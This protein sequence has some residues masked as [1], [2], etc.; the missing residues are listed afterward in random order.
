MN[1]NFGD[2]LLYKELHDTI[3]RKFGESVEIISSEVSEFY[4]QFSPVIR[5]PHF[6]AMKEADFIVFGGGGYFGEGTRKKFLWNL[7]FVR[8]YGLKATSIAMAGKKFII[9]GVG[10]GPFK[11]FFSRWMTRYIFNRADYIS[12]RDNESKEFLKRIGVKKD[13]EMH[14]DWILGM[15]VKDVIATAKLSEKVKEVCQ[16]EYL[17][18]HL[19]SKYTDN[20]AGLGL[21]TKEILAYCK[22]KDVKV[23]V[24]CDQTKEDVYLRTKELSR[25]FGDS[26][27][28]YYEYKSPYELISLIGS[29]KMIITDKL[30][31]G[32]VGV[33]AGTNVVS[34]PL[35][36]KTPRL[37]KQIG[38]SDYCKPIKDVAQGD[39]YKLLDKAYNNIPSDMSTIC[40]AS[41]Y[42][43]EI[44]ISKIDALISDCN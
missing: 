1:D 39:I 10:A 5:M 28:F 20:D 7:A 3:T 2:Y 18:V 38:R 21:V 36:S 4:D 33:A 22:N 19:I 31:V 34:V 25:R 40:E 32:I 11:Y 15:D 14:P 23:V 29:A 27:L 9:V 17:L 16:K 13:V 24:T 12:V 6:K 26:L 37:Y 30:H 8:Y 42:N 41:R 44:V 35:H 43:R